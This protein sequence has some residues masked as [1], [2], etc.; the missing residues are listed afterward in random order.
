MAGSPQ[1]ELAMGLSL[2]QLAAFVPEV[3]TPEVLAAIGEHL[4][5]L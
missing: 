5:K 3:L 2:T 1:I 4:A